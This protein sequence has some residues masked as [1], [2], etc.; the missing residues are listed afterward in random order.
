LATVID[1][2]AVYSL[3]KY[4]EVSRKLSAQ[5]TESIDN[6]GESNTKVTL[7]TVSTNPKS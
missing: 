2:C 5:N 6:K 1:K 4:E 7:A 3:E